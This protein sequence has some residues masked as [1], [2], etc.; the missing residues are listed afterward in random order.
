MT[1]FSTVGVAAVTIWDR[2][3]KAFTAL[4]FR[5]EYGADFLARVTGG[6]IDR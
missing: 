5:L 6:S 2:C 4:G 1:L 3:S